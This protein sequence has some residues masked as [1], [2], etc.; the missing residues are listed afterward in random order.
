MQ[1]HTPDGIIE[2]NPDTATDAE[3]L[4]FSVTRERL[5]AIEPRNF[6]KELDDLKSELRA[7]GVI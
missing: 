7:K 4:K 2:I 6:A 5:K 1:L 3:L